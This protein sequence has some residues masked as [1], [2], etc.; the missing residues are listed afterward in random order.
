[1]AFVWLPLPDP[2]RYR[3]VVVHAS[4]G[5]AWRRPPNEQLAREAG[6]TLNWQHLDAAGNIEASASIMH[7]DAEPMRKVLDPL[8]TDGT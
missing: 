3:W 7:G 5:R 4:R 6:F 2:A 8:L 1:V